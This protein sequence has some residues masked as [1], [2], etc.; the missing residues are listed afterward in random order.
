MRLLRAEAY[1]ED[2]EQIAR[3]IAK[4]KPG[5]ALAM[6]KAIET[7]VERLKN[8]P[9]SGRT[10]RA[11]GTRELVI[12]RTPFIVIYRVRQKLERVE[13]IRVLHGAQKWPRI[14]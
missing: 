4:D 10:G 6:W 14:D 9:N 7:Q 1:A 5:A 8:F 12:P 11:A 13:I 2:L 3:A